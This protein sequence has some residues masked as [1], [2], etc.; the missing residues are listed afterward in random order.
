[1]K[2]NLWKLIGPILVAGFLLPAFASSAQ[3]AEESYTCMVYFTGIG[4]THCAKSDPVVLEQLPREYQDLII[5]E[6][7]IYQ[8]EQNAPLLYEYS[9]SYQTVLEIPLVVFSQ[10]KHVSDDSPILENI[11]GMVEELNSNECP[12]PDGSSQDF[13]HLDPVTLPGYAKIWHREKVLIKTGPE[14]DG[15]LLKKLLTSDNLSEILQGAEF[16]IIESPRVPVSGGTIEFD[17]GIRIG[18]WIFQWNGEALETLPPE[19]EALPPEEEVL[20]PEEEVTPT[21]TTKPTFSPSKV[22]VLAAADAV[23]PCAFAVLLLMLTSILIFNPGDRRRVV[24][25]GLA[26]TAAVFA[27]YFL[28]GLLIIK[29]FQII[30]ALAPARFWIYQGLAV[31]ATVFGALNIRDGIRY[32]PGRAGTEMPLSMRPRLQRLLSKITSPRGAALVGIFV[33]V[34]LLPCTIGPYVIA[35]GILSVRDIVEN[36]PILLLYNLV[37]IAPFLAIVGGLHLGLRKVSDISSWKDRNVGKLHLIAGILIL[38]L[39]I[40]MLT[41]LI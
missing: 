5:I 6:Y 8:Q 33:T 41:G 30:Q 4:C 32:K 2:M 40:A 25:S 3:A 38:G 9:S 11:R 20:P 36:I 10:D 23:N 19:E 16:E 21:E 14:G 37:F 18:D 1:M 12:L 7:E 17:H 24:H 22:L 26:F 29:A 35:G 31:A 15:E 27:M 13:N 34:F 39:G 28:Y